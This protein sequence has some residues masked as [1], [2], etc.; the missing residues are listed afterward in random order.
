M[1]RHVSDNQV[2]SILDRRHLEDVTN[3]H[4]SSGQQQLQ[5]HHDG[6]RPKENKLIIDDELKNLDPVSC[7]KKK[8]SSKENRVKYYTSI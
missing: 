5:S 8:N 6:S 2:S 4:Q 3:H 1:R 7:K